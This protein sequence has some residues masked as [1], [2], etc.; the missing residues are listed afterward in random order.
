MAQ[1]T[2]SIS[3]MVNDRPRVV[4]TVLVA[5]ASFEA[6]REAA[7]TEINEFER[8]NEKLVV[9]DSSVKVILRV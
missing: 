3:I 5:G 6:I 1:G 9:C 4:H 2:L 7:I 8:R